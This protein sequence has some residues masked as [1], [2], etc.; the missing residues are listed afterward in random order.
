MVLNGVVYDITDYASK[1]P[2]GTIIFDAAGKDGT[3]LFS[4]FHNFSEILTRILDKYHSWVNGNF[5]LKGKEVGAYQ[6]N[7]GSSGGGSMGNTLKV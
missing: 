7:A 6:F 1:H 5:I 3:A 4:K 2:G